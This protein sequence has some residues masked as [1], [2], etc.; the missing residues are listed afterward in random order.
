MGVKV[1][2]NTRDQ[3]GGIRIV[4]ISFL[5]V[6]TLKDRSGSINAHKRKLPTVKTSKKTRPERRCGR[7][8]SHSS[9]IMALADEARVLLL[10]LVFLSVTRDTARKNEGVVGCSLYKPK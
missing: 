5:L 1:H 4:F 6:T 9:V 7:D 8:G 10:P 3:S 2:S